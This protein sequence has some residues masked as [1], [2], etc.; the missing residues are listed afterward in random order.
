MPIDG[1]FTIA[2][3]RGHVQDRSAIGIALTRQMLMRNSAKPHP[4][5]AHDVES[6]AIFYQSIGD[7]KEGVASFLE[8]RTPVFTSKASEMP[9]FYP[10][11]N[12]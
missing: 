3:W 2:G 5:F 10:W 7:G 11:E 12:V 1:G 6:L 8:K 9:P 4:R